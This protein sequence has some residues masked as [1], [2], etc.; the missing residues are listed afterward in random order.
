MSVVGICYDRTRDSFACLGGHV[1]RRE[2]SL[3]LA[4]ANPF[5]IRRARR[6]R[7][8]SR[9]RRTMIMLMRRMMA[10][11]RTTRTRRRR[12]RRTSR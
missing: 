8:K 4:P 10:M 3:S 5:R 1:T 12:T 9:R 6:K 11:R 7:K 2:F